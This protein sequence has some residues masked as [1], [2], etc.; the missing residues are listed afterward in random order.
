MDVIDV[1]A[2]PTPILYYAAYTLPVDGGVMV[3]GS[4]NPPRY[5]GF[6]LLKGKDTLFGEYIQDLKKIID[7]SS[8]SVGD[9]KVE[10]RDLTDEYINE[11]VGRV[12]IDRKVKIV[13]DGGNGAGGLIANEIYTKMGCEVVPLYLEPDGNFPNHHPDPTVDENTVDLRSKVEES[14]ADIGIGFDGDA[15]RAGFIADDGGIMRGDQALILYSRDILSRNPGAK[16]ISEVK[17]SQALFEDVEANGGIPIMYRT[18]HSF[19]KKKL[20][21]EDAL[22]AGEM[23]GHFFFRE[24]WYGFDDAIYAG[25]RMLEIV[26]KSDKPVSMLLASLPGYVSTPEI[27][28]SC[29]DDKK[30]G[31]VEAVT[32]SFIEQ[33]LNVVT[34]D[35]ARVE[36]GDGWGLVRAS[37]TSPKL[38]LRFEAKTQEKLDE[39]R[40]II[41]S[42]VRKHPEA[43]IQ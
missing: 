7:D 18:G 34:V 22:V 11:V 33:G 37:N 40:D 39:I 16:I 30:F 17:S 8:F 32:K 26:S 20:K 28:V 43:K 23:S 4:H 41:L 38:I 25:A 10:E 9:G 5:N 3:T 6:K 36:F 42:E 14:G 12:K 15:D 24:N 29:P 31:I 27:R 21:E 2:V 19:I 1:G 35:G 13:V